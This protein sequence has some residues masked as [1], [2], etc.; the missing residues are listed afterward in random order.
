MPTATRV[1]ERE[2]D[3]PMSMSWTP[4]RVL[5]LLV[6]LALIGF[7]T[8]IFTG[9]PRKD[10]P[11]KLIDRAYVER[12][13][14]RCARMV[15]EIAALPN[16]AGLDDAAERAD[17]LDRATDLVESMV[18]DLESRPPTEAA[19]REVVDLWIDDWRTYV[20]DRRAYGDTLRSDPSAQFVLTENTDLS[21][22]VDDTIETFA[23]VNDMASCVVPGDVG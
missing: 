20:S 15:D 23:K 19:D 4:A 8:W 18:D 2:V 16:P 1:P 22:G 12:S 10:N 13:E 6:A 9:G 3:E 7:W 17:L 11:D 5:G 14:D 21:Y